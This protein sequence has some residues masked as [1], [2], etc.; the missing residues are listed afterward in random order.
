MMKRLM[1]RL[2]FGCFALLL[3]FGPACSVRSFSVAGP[4]SL[5][6]R[7]MLS[8]STPLARTF[9]PASLEPDV[10]DSTPLLIY[11][12]YDQVVI[13]SGPPKPQPPPA[14]GGK[15][16]IRIGGTGSQAGTG[17]CADWTT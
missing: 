11:H 2:S 8:A 17:N 4:P 6:G 7:P 3:I 12:A 1:G 13:L 5:Q 9:E 14:E 10:L 16:Y 15:H